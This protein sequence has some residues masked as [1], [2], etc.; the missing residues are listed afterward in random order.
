MNQI[1]KTGL[2]L[3]LLLSQINA[4]ASLHHQP[5]KMAIFDNPQIADSD[6]NVLAQSLEG[7]YLRGINV[8]IHIANEKGYH[9]EQKAFFYNKNL[10]NILQKVPRIKAWDPD[11]I[12]GLHTS[13]EAL[14]S[15]SMFGQLLVLSIT[16]TDKK[17][18]HLSPNFYTLGV[19]DPYISKALIRFI[20]EHFPKKNLFIMIGVESK[21]SLDFGRSIANAYKQRYPHHTA[22][23]KEFLTNDLLSMSP[24]SLL[25]GYH[26]NDIIV[27]FSI[28]GTYHSQL[29]LMNKLA[30][31]LAPN[32]PTFITT[33]DNWRDDTT[34]NNSNL[35]LPP[36]HAYRITNL[37]ENPKHL[38]TKHSLTPI[39]RCI[40]HDL[41]ILSVTLHTEP[42][43]R[44][45]QH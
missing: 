17:L 33:V 32:P 23:I 39:K 36:Y 29:A 3:L 21:E 35:P 38:Y 26:K 27:M 18:I 13:N 31:Y 25:E 9:I 7:A 14:M 4:F 44:S 1:L 5:I 20:G 42:L 16:A 2:A 22:V 41:T 43:C 19:P 24:K 40:T 34:L 6:G 10:L 30:K 11:V 12:I 45:L 15:Q 37:Y 8:A 28:A